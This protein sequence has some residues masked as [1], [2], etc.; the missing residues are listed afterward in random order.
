MTLCD[1]RDRF[2]SGSASR[3]RRGRKENG[4]VSSDM[5][6]Q[7][8]MSYYEKKYRK[9]KRRVKKLLSDNVTEKTKNL[10]MHSNH[11]T[12]VAQYE[13]LEKTKQLLHKAQLARLSHFFSANLRHRILHSTFSGLKLCSRV[14]STTLCEKLQH[15]TFIKQQKI[16]RSLRKYAV[17][18]NQRRHQHRLAKLRAKLL[19]RVLLKHNV[20]KLLRQSLTKWRVCASGMQR[21]S[22]VEQMVRQDIAS[23]SHQMTLMRRIIAV[24]KLEKVC[25]VRERDHKVSAFG[26]IMMARGA[27]KV[28]TQVD[29][30]R[31]QSRNKGL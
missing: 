20:T 27:H 31:S 8:R 16:L 17:D 28:N 30:Q 21:V 4:V 25:T 7:E 1:S 2:D 10:E 5:M 6:L 24:T 23:A 3:N 15:F 9:S 26:K 13:V 11:C 22:Q 19:K 14:H 18:R 29:R 12:L